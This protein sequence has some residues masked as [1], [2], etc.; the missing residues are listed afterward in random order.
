MNPGRDDAPL[1]IDRRGERNIPRDLA[2]QHAAM[3]EIA[4]ELARGSEPDND[5]VRFV[6]EIDRAERDDRAF[7]PWNEVKI[8]VTLSALSFRDPAAAKRGVALPVGIEPDH[9]AIPVGLGRHQ[10]PA[11][12]IEL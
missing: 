10:D 4:L 11:P 9:D 5:A 2:A 3:S 1:I 8:R 7:A 6:S 12:V